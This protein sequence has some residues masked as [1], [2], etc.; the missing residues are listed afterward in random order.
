M[1]CHI[2]ALQPGKGQKGGLYASLAQLS[3]TGLDVSTEV[4]DLK[5]PK[6]RVWSAAGSA[7]I[8]GL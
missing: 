3:D 8:I 7:K 2:Q 5:E 6:Y 1:L 4:D